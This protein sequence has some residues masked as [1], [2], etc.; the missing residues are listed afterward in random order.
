MGK[1][2][3]G[4]IVVVVLIWGLYAWQH[5]NSAPAMMDE[6]NTMMPDDTGMMKKDVVTSIKD[7]M[8]LGQKMQCSYTSMAGDQ[9]VTSTVYVD[10]T[11]FKSDSVVHG[12]TIHALFDGETQYTWT[13]GPTNTGMKMSK[14]C[15]DEMKN[16]MPSTAPQGAQPEDYSKSFDTAHDVKC[17]PV[18][19]VDFSLPTDVT[20]TDQC[21]MMQKSMDMMKQMKTQMPEGAPKP[22]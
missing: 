7:A 3:G 16:N 22:Y 15:L 14:A 1:L 13:E 17:E 11:K 19:S 9:S 18:S 21:A 10:G 4:I 12:A 2:I 5:K 8:G 6:S 20:F